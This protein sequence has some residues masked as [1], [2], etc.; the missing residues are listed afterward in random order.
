MT[1]LETRDQ[2]LAAAHDQGL[3]LTPDTAELDLSGADYIV[4]HAVD[5]EGAAWVV[6]SPRRADVMDGASYERRALELVRPRLPVAVPDWRLFTPELIAYPRLDGDPAAVV[7]LAAGGY[8]WRFD[9][10]APPPV[11]LDSFADAVAALHGI[12]PEAARVAEV[13]VRSPA[14]LREES[15][16]RVE[17]A[18]EVL[19]VPRAVR[20]RWDRW[21]KDDTCWPV[22]GVPVHGDLHPA[23]ILVDGEH[24]VSGLLDWTELHVGDPATD[25]TFLYATL[26]RPALARVLARYRAA[27]REVWDRMEEHVVETW[28]AYPVVLAD[29]AEQTED[30]GPLQLAQY[31]VD[32]NAREMRAGGA[33]AAINRRPRS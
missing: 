30:D 28:S 21:L 29:F 12:D 17:R 14:E 8:V 5:A 1:I 9:E 33:A 16:W 22:H 19:H 3:R 32:E 4:V 24:R 15:A 31:L 2:I 7:D 20:T 6:R 10:K 13:P 26:G 27:G 18:R 23:H 25:F 11:F